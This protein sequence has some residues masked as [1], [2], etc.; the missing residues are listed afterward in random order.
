MSDQINEIVMTVL[1]QQNLVN[2]RKPEQY[3]QPDSLSSI[4]NEPIDVNTVG[5]PR[6]TDYSMRMNNDNNNLR[7]RNPQYLGYGILNYD[8]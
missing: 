4:Y 3:H 1:R 7:Y 8:M 5:R 2:D 6:V